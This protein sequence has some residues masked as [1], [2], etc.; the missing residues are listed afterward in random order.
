MIDPE[1]YSKNLDPYLDIVKNLYQKQSKLIQWKSEPESIMDLGIG[2]G[3]MSKQVLF[4]I[5]PKP[6]LE[7]IGVDV[8]QEML[9]SAKNTYNDD[10]FS[11][12]QLNAATK[13]V[14]NELKNRFD[15]IFSS[16]L[17]H[18]IQDTR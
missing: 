7:F 14:P 6:L 1:N 9:V 4:P 8:S 18:H 15:H 2:D 10:K 5:V 3:K 13:E 11:T 16:F 12:F 17:F